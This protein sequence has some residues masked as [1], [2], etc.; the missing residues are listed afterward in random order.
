MG[1]TN[2][3]R[4]LQSRRVCRHTH[5]HMLQFVNGQDQCESL[6]LSHGYIIIVTSVSSESSLSFSSSPCSH[7]SLS[8][9]FS[10]ARSLSFSSSVSQKHTNLHFG[11]HDTVFWWPFWYYPV[12]FVR[13]LGSYVS[14]LSF[15]AITSST[16]AVKPPNFACRLFFMAQFRDGLTLWLLSNSVYIFKIRKLKIVSQFVLET[17]NFTHFTR[18][19]WRTNLPFASM[20]FLEQFLFMN[21]TDNN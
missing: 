7:F 1:G 2:E 8:S 19:S 4:D 20:M 11:M 5:T 12:M 21:Q 15:L 9:L 16:C 18:F 17:S 10:L 14:F 13:D 3:L 6:S